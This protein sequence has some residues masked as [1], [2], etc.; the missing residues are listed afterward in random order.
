MPGS[1]HKFLVQLLIPRVVSLGYRVVASDQ[2][3][4]T[5]GKTNIPSPPAVARHRPDILGLRNTPPIFCIGEAK[6]VG[7]LRTRHTRQQLVDF[8][9]VI[10]SHV[11]IAIPAGGLSILRTV[12]EEEGL[13]FGPHLECLPVPE[14]LLPDQ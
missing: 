1:V 7:D 4:Y 2:S 12:L 5:L 3:Y 10:D 9:S 11:I 13:V 8:V 6:T 14:V